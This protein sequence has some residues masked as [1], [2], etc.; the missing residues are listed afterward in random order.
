ISGWTTDTL[1]SHILRLLED[2]DD[3]SRLAR[4]AD[5][6][7]IASVVHGMDTR[8]TAMQTLMDEH[9]LRY[10]QRFAASQ[11]A[12][13]AALNAQ[14][15]AIAAALLAADRAVNKAEIAREKRF[16]GVHE[17]RQ[18]LADQA[19]TFMPRAEAE[20]RLSSLGEKLDQNTNQ[21]SG[22]AGRSAAFK[23][24]AQIVYYFFAIGVAI[25]A[26]LISHLIH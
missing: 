26:V 8:F 9:D 7:H 19:A 15:E 4:D 1:H 17:F 24:S 10:Q 6:R 2:R 20:I 16:E 22:G 25:A 13:T 18:Q 21:L 12:L 23:D 11:E 14:K 5:L 3:A